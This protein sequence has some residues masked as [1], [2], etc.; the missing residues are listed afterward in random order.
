MGMTDQP[1]LAGVE[2][3]MTELFF[4]INEPILA[5]MKVRVLITRVVYCLSKLQFTQIGKPGLSETTF[6]RFPCDD[7]PALKAL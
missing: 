4:L 5:F 7:G 2:K 3:L 1:Y 6:T